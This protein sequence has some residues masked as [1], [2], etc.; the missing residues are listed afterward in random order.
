VGDDAEI[1]RTMRVVDRDGLHAR[2]CARIARAAQKFKC[3]VTATCDGRVGDAKS[4]LEL[5]QLLAAGGA[6]VEFS[7]VGAD[8]AKCLDAIAVEIAKEDRD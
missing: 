2:P 1:V 3:A 5:L 4:V 6:D 8:A 7:A